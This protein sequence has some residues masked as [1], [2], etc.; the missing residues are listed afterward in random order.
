[1]KDPKL[2][3]MTKCEYQGRRKKR[4]ECVIPAECSCMCCSSG[5]RFSGT[6]LR[7]TWAGIHL[8]MVTNIQTTQGA[9]DSS[10]QTFKKKPQKW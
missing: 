2:E 8:N 3:R 10:N 5:I 7:Q 1:M 9:L 6:N 4:E